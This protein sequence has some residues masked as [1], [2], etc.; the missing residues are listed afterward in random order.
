[1]HRRSYLA[2]MAAGIGA[3]AGR[4][5]DGDDP[6]RRYAPSAWEE[7]EELPA[8]A[9]TSRR[10]MPLELGVGEYSYRIWYPGTESYVEIEVDADNPMEV[11]VIS[12]DQADALE[13]GEPVQYAGDVHANGSSFDVRGV[14]P[15]GSYWLVADNS[16]HG[17][18]K[19]E[20]PVTATYIQE[21]GV[22]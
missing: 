7:G 15:K 13:A 2:A 6:A 20:G 18:L 17:E 19:P 1:M 22:A 21:I 3:L 9:G 11:F 8:E 4:S 16:D 12:E 10:R 5:G 14:V